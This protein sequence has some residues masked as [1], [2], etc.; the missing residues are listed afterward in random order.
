[1]P[2]H[3]HLEVVS[4][5]ADPLLTP[6]QQLEQKLVLLRAEVSKLTRRIPW[7]PNTRSSNAFDER[8]KRV[9]QTLRPVFTRFRKRETENLSDDY[10]WLY[11]NLR[12]LSAAL[13]DVN[14]G[15]RSLR[16]LPHVRTRAGG[17]EQRVLAI[18]E[19]FLSATEFQFSD[20]SISAFIEGFQEITVLN[21]K[22]LWAFPPALKLTL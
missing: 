9:R 18:S 19:A 21:M 3:E 16:K 22:E 13:E 17:V 4:S 2:D 5:G 11:D 15:L 6:E 8:L 20:Q 1:M 7:L 10:R 14:D 12:L